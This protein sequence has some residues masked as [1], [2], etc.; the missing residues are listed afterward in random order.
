[1]PDINLSSLA[2]YPFTDGTAPTGDQVS[3]VLHYPR[4]TPGNFAVLNGRLTRSNLDSTARPLD[5]ELIR[6]GH[7][8]FGSQRGATLNTDILLGLYPGVQSKS[9]LLDDDIFDVEALPVLATQFYNPDEASYVRLHWRIGFYHDDDRAAAGQDPGTADD[10]RAR[11]R[12]FINGRPIRPVT[13]DIKAARKTGFTPSVGS[14]WGRSTF[15]NGRWWTG[16]IMIDGF[17]TV[18]QGLG[19]GGVSPLLRGWHTASLRV[20]AV[21]EGATATRNKLIRVRARIMGYTVVK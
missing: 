2:F 18:S 12:L 5:K 4:A 7:L 16:N 14:S 8:S 20:A 21:Y 1:M 6:K 17:F 10:F 13:R 3:E 19:G 11:V 15:P 9:D